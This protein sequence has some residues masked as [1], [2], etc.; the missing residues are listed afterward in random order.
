[1]YFVITKF[2][3]KLSFENKLQKKLFQLPKKNNYFYCVGLFL[4]ILKRLKK[5]L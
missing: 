2:L 5:D 4:S 3:M 1:M